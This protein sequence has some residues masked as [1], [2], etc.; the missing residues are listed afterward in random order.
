MVRFARTRRV[1]FI[2][3]PVFDAESAH[4]TIRKDAGVRVVTPRLIPDL[5]EPDVLAIQSELLRGLFESEHIRQPLLWFYTPMALPLVD[6]LAASGVVYDCMDELSGFARAP[7]AIRAA[8]AALLGRTDVVFTGGHSLYE[9]KRPLHGNVHA[10]PSSVDVE[11]FARARTIS[12]EPQDQAPIPH[13]RIGFCGVIDE[14]MN[15]DLVARVAERRPDWHLVMIGPTVKIDPADLPQSPNIHYLGMKRY[16][17]LPAYFSGWDVAMMPF[18]HNA[19][20]RFIS[21]TKTPEYL[22]A[23]CPVVSTS[24]RDVVRPYGERG[25]VAIADTTDDFCAAIDM[26]LTAFGRLSV[27]SAASLL[28]TMSWDRTF[29]GMQK[30]IDRALRSARRAGKSQVPATVEGAI[31]YSPTVS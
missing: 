31:G 13:P 26:S 5:E 9:A 8:E 19:A 11:H 23:G 20:T 14:R 24:I 4:L 2:E 1:F 16:E 15:L 22:A 7:I 17:E 30:A 27:A 21:P 3:E 28:K 6:G 29:E 18:A 12:V 25:Y 10:F